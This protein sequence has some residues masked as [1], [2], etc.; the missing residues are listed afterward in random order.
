M[1]YNSNNFT[2]LLYSL[3]PFFKQYL[4]GFIMLSSCICM[5]LYLLWTS[6]PPSTLSNS[7]PLLLISLPWSPF[8]TC[9]I[10]IVILIT[11]DLHFTHEQKLVILGF[12]NLAYFAQNN[13]LQFH[14]FSCKWYNFVLYGWIKFHCVY[15][16]THT[17]THTYTHIYVYSTFSLSVHLL[18]DT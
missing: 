17:H 5:I 18:I 2:P 1:Q 15:T 3:S 4:V 9:P 14:I 8:Y 10:V 7:P 12:L 16:H 6:S 13:D 11:L